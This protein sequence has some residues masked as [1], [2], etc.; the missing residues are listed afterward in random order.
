MKKCRRCKANAAKGRRFCETHLDALREDYRVYVAE[1]RKSKICITCNG[2]KHWKTS[3][4]C[5]GCA[6]DRYSRRRR[7]SSVRQVCRRCGSAGHGGNCRVPPFGWVGTVS[8]LE[9]QHHVKMTPGERARAED[10]LVEARTEI[11]RLQWE[12]RTGQRIVVSR[13]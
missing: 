4:E 11:K 2:E 3:D 12:L 13:R 9:R 1:C 8:A 5:Q 6:E 10:R 7:R